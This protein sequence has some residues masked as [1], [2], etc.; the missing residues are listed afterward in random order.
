[1]YFS[2][3]FPTK[4]SS[5]CVSFCVK[6]VVGVVV[7]DTGEIQRSSVVLHAHACAHFREP[8]LIL[9]IHA[10][11]GEEDEEEG[12]GGASCW[13]DGVDIIIHSARRHCS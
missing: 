4:F 9:F 13:L 3:P 8:W 10:T 6:E 2:S 5:L 1:M 7:T 12:E 11:S